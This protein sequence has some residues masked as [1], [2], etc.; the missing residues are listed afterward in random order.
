MKRLIALVV[1]LSLV[2]LLMPAGSTVE[3]ESLY[4]RKV[5]SVVYDDSGSMTGAG[6]NWAYANYAM[7][8]FCGLLNDDDQLYITYMS[9]P[10][11]SYEFTDMD[12]QEAVD[13]LSA[14]A[15]S[16]GTPYEAV[17]TAFNTLCNVTDYDENTQFWLVIFTDGDMGKRAG[18]LTN[19]FSQSFGKTAMPNGSKPYISYFGIGTGAIVPKN[20]PSNRIYVSEAD[21]SKEIFNELADIAYKISGRYRVD[22][23]DVRVVDNRTVELTSEVALLNIAVLL[24]NSSSL[25]T[26]IE[27]AEATLSLD[28]QIMLKTP[29]GL[30]TWVTDPTLHGTASLIGNSGGGVIPPGTYRLTFSED[31]DPNHITFMFEPAIYLRLT[32]TKGGLEVTDFSQVYSGDTIDVQSTICE[33]GTDRE[34]SSKL[35]PGTVSYDISVTEDGSL[36]AQVQQSTLGGIVLGAVPTQITGKVEIDGIAPLTAVIHLAPGA[37]PITGLEVVSGTDLEIELT[38][39]RRNKDGVTF[40]M[41]IDGEQAT[42]LQVAGRKLKVDSRVRVDIEQQP[43]GTWLVVPTGVWPSIFNP[44]GEITITGSLDGESASTT[45]KIVCS[46]WLIPFI[47]L[48]LPILILIFLICQIMRKRFHRDAIQNLTYIISNNNVRLQG[49]AGGGDSVDVG[50]LTN[51]IGLVRP[52]RKKYCDIT[53]LANST[54]FAAPSVIVS[55]DSL[56][57]RVYCTL[58][59]APSVPQ[60]KAAVRRLR[61]TT[62][63]KCAQQ[64]TGDIVL[65]G[66]S[67]IILEGNTVELFRMEDEDI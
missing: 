55:K 28:R 50:P 1:A 7:Q 54:L 44:V 34:I 57:G 58:S 64:Y 65:T 39:L 20:D 22:K 6:A 9:D 25:I 21:G 27:C 48:L 16:S 49:G 63:E 29:V 5:V 47:E 51:V 46:N 62:A 61:Q 12:R 4:V 66:G 2:L 42:P 41:L 67:L 35:L 26:G 17:E 13:R 15:R 3:A 60:I 40:Y 14:H 18:E 24:Q 52:C 30:P 53:F 31:I 36:S 33:M 43:D 38:E 19:I 11:T 56:E 45:V 59:H 37:I 8:T 23:G 10:F 32:I